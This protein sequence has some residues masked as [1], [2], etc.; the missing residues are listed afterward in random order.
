MFDPRQMM[1]QAA[2]NRV[3]QNPAVRQV[4]QMKQQG[5]NPQQAMQQLSQ[6]Y[7]QL[8]QLQGMNQAQLENMAINAMRQNGIDPDMLLGQ[9]KRML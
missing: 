3:T 8:Q 7:P 5:M 9:F 4:L 2:M 6:Q 1:M